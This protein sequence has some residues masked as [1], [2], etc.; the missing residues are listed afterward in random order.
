[1]TTTVDIARITADPAAWPRA[2]LEPERVAD[3]AD[4]Y[5]DGGPM[6][7]PPISVIDRGDDF[8]LADG[9]H[10]LAAMRRLGADTVPAELVNAGGRDAVLVAYETGLRTSAT[11]S[12]PL[13]R[14]EKQEAVRRLDQA[15]GRTDQ[16]IAG[17]VGVARTTVARIRLRDGG[18]AQAEP[19]DGRSE[20]ELEAARRLFRG[21]ERVFDA[22]GLGIGDAIFGDRTGD[23]LAEVL[24]SAF[25]EDAAARAIRY[26]GWIDRAI[27]SLDQ[28]VDER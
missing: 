24:R 2:E 11:A 27:S 26:R 4:L 13:T 17:L 7:L 14:A 12:R 10:R 22:R 6:A 3:F 15:G 23:R 18:A 9:W 28:E 8:L 20:T 21:L 16:E 5:R 19:R 1:M 25:G